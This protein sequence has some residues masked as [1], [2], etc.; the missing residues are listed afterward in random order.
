MV[1]G[2]TPMR[3]AASMVLMS[4]FVTECAPQC[5]PLPRL[6]A[7]VSHPCRCFPDGFSAGRLLV[8]GAATVVEQLTGEVLNLGTDEGDRSGSIG[9]R[10]GIWLVV[11]RSGLDGIK[12]QKGRV[13]VPSQITNSPVPFL[14]TLVVRLKQEAF[15]RIAES[16]ARALVALAVIVLVAVKG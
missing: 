9:C 13:H 10:I 7:P 16:A 4:D 6:Y 11:K 5:G 12:R 15:Q 8:I 1:I 3:A 14:A 2:A